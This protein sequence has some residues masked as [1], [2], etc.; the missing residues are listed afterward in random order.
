MTVD[1]VN[2]GTLTMATP[3]W[4]GL[5]LISCVRWDEV[6]LQQGTPL[7]GALF[8]IGTL[9]SA[10]VAAVALLTAGGVFLVAHI[11]LLNDCCG[12]DEDVKVP[13]RSASVFL[14]RG[15]LRAHV[16]YL[17][18]ALLVLGFLLLAPLGL[19]TLLIAA[20]IAI[21]SSLYSGPLLCGKGI[22]VLSSALHIV[23]GIL[24]FLLG[25][26]LFCSLD[27][28]GLETGAFFALSFAAGH[29][30]H[31]ARDRDGDYG[32]GIQTNAVR[33][34]TRR[35][36]CAGLSLF[37]I[38]YA[39]LVML[40]WRG[41]VP[42]LLLLTGAIYPLHL[43]FSMRTLRDGLTFANIRRLQ[44]HYRILYSVVGLLIAVS[45]LPSLQP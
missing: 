22:P 6:L 42:R 44:A 12:A 25:Y 45:M 24:H 31:E 10:K 18:V 9:T 35:G 43:Y 20:G 34:G 40:A 2:S 39:L 5:G 4:R 28:R 8:S 32:C 16:G 13:N 41:L 36:F 33:F 23:G 19:R 27:A 1:T 11:F 21:V 14:S 26:S 17:C 15:F 30:T 29:L 3:R 38:A 7:F 37:T